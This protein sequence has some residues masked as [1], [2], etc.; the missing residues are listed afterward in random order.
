MRSGADNQEIILETSLVQMVGF[1][2]A[3]GPDQWAGRAAAGG[4]EGWLSIYLGVGRGRKWEV[5][6]SIFIC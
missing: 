6:E 4:C 5:S 3:Q 2:K 1:I